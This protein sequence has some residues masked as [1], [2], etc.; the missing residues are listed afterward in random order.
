[1]AVAPLS[2]TTIIK[3]YN[4]TMNCMF[5]NEC[6]I[7]GNKLLRAYVVLF[8][9]VPNQNKFSYLLIFQFKQEQ[10]IQENKSRQLQQ[11]IEIYILVLLTYL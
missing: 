1:M 3:I 2:E 5:L 9:H 4:V 8:Y 7:F 6:F 11:F 10:E